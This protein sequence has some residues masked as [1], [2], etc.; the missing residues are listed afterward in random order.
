M[1][2][3]LLKT[4]SLT[5]R[6]L[7]VHSQN[8][9]HGDLTAANVLIDDNEKACLTDFGLSSIKEEFEG[10]SFLSVSGSL[11]SVQHFKSSTFIQSTIGGALRFRALEISPPVEGSY[12]NFKPELTFACDVYSLGSVILQVCFIKSLL[13]QVAQCRTFSRLYPVS[14]LITTLKISWFTWHLFESWNQNVRQSAGIWPMTT[15]ISFKFVG[16]TRLRIGP[17]LRMLTRK[18]GVFETQTSARSSLLSNY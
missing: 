18:S 7:L 4:Y 13:I 3:W 5:P 10:T 16:A 14:S 15:G 1:L 12:E 6:Y 8:I 17:L 2:T 11:L 9:M